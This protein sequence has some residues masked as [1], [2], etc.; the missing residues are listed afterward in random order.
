[1]DV[2][3]IRHFKLHYRCILASR[4]LQAAE[5]GHE[6]FKWSLLDCLLAVKS[7][8]SLVKPT[9]IV[10]CYR[11]ADFVYGDAPSRAE[12]IAQV[13]SNP[14]SKLQTFTNIWDVLNSTI[15]EMPSLQD[16]IDVDNQVDCAK[17]MTNQ[18]IVAEVLN[19]RLNT[20]MTVK[21]VY[22]ERPEVSIS[23][24]LKIIRF[25]S[26]ICTS[27]LHQLCEN[28]YFVLLIIFRKSIMHTTQDQM[29]CTICS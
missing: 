2:G 7:A 12:S 8:W 3:V 6:D 20:R 22:Q 27:L 9:T 10:N 24:P 17:R 16:Y 25:F 19:N 15:L 5:N 13:E 1:M 23:T 11:N 29:I 28:V 14:E 21:N 26:L 18:E 4:R